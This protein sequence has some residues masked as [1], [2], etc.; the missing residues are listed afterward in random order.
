MKNQ[1][2]ITLVALV[3][4]IVVLII[5]AGVAINMTLGENGIFNRAKYAKIQYELAQEKEK[6]EI[7][8]LNIQTETMETEGRVA[9]LNDLQEKIDTTKYTSELHY[10]ALDSEENINSV[11]TYAIVNKVNTNYYFTVDSKLVITDVRLGELVEEQTYTVTFNANGGICDIENKKISQ[12]SN[13]GS[14][15]EPTRDGYRFLGW[16]SDI[17]NGSQILETDIVTANITLYAKWEE[18]PVLIA[19]YD[20]I[21]NTNDGHSYEIDTW[22][23]LS[24]NNERGATLNG[25]TWTE[26]GLLFDGDDWVDTNSILM[27]EEENFAINMVFSLNNYPEIN[28]CILGQNASSVPE[29]RLGL[30]FDNENGLYLFSGVINESI[31]SEYIPRLTEKVDVTIMKNDGKLE[32]WINATKMGE[33]EINNLTIDQSNTVLGR[34]GFYSYSYLTGTIYSVKAYDKELIQQEIQ[35]NYLDNAE[36]FKINSYGDENTD[37]YV[38]D[39]LVGWYDG[40]NNTGENH[41]YETDIWTDLTGNN[42]TGATVTGATWTPNGLSFDGDDFVNMNTILMPET[43][44]FSIDIVCSINKSLTDQYYILGQTTSTGPA[45]RAGILYDGANGLGI[46]SSMYNQQTGYKPKLDEK[47][48]ITYRRNGTN[49]DMWINGNKLMEKSV[50]NFKVYQTNTILGSWATAYHL[51]GVINSVRTYNKALSDS[52]IQQNYN[53]DKLRFDM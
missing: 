50:E 9:T 33:K 16:H 44:N 17:E 38:Q 47:V 48:T 41:N 37:N 10:E 8:I 42:T 14:L 20:G 25:A 43:D 19:W 5:L 40:F 36:R 26:D 6:L 2:G 18:A 23:D 39:G 12:N 15:P 34:W 35:E 53:V 30:S 31:P 7:E 21:N 45:Y 11:P 49:L 4:T 29:N 13:Y 24:G 27:P 28:S 1:K 3:I 51:K 46:F 32:L 22:T 52:E